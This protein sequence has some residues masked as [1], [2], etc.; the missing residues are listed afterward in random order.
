M[1]IY[2]TGCNYATIFSFQVRSSI[3]EKFNFTQIFL[4]QFDLHDQTSILPQVSSDSDDDATDSNNQFPPTTVHTRTYHRKSTI[5][6]STKIFAIHCIQTLIK[7]CEQTSQS[8][9]SSSTEYLL[10][11]FPIFISSSI[12]ACTSKH[13]SLRL[14][15]FE[16]LKQ[17]ILI[18][19][20]L[21]ESAD[22]TI[23]RIL[24]HYQRQIGAA[25]RPAFSR[26]TSSNVTIE[27]CDLCWIWISSQCTPDLHDLR[28]VHQILLA[29]L[30]KLTSLQEQCNKKNNMIFHENAGTMEILAIL[31]LWA[32]VYTFVIEQA[33]EK[34]IRQ[35]LPLIQRELYVLVHHWLA[36]LTDYA[37]FILSIRSNKTENSHSFESIKTVTCSSIIQATTQWLVD[38]HFELELSPTNQQLINYGQRDVLMAKLLTSMNKSRRIPEKKEDIFIIL[39]TCSTHVL[40]ISLSDQ[41]IDRSLSPL[42]HLL[43][44]EIAHSQINIKISL[45]L[46]DVLH[47]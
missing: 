27:A 38:H 22:L 45:E 16:L 6:W 41:T 3:S 13:D 4:D 42:M 28:R 30:Q 18:F 12:V 14:A 35:L 37:T 33:K 47:R 21:E 7:Y 32:D 44:S 5:R 39:L 36:V 8:N 9:T 1:M 19:T 20:R 34:P 15:G 25:L 26:Q 23:H 24:K 29:S 10:V 46:I 40:S 11:H 31:K 17:I 43:Q 2:L